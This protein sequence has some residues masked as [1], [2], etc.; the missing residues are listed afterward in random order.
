LGP[1]G[2]KNEK[3]VPL[4]NVRRQ[5]KFPGLSRT[6]EPML[7]SPGLIAYECPRCGRVAALLEAEESR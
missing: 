7:G 1:L 2:F 6:I 3:L 4:K 5:G